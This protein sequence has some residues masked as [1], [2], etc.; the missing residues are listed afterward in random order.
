M[1][2]LALLIGVYSHIIF[3]L[4]IAGFFYRDYI[5]VFTL[6][7]IAASL[8][9]SKKKFGNMLRQYFNAWKHSKR[10]LVSI[11]LICLIALQILINFI[12]ALG[13]ELGFDSLWYHLTLPKI[14]LIN[15]S[16][17]YIPGGLF[18]YSAMP[19]LTEMLY[20]AAL[21]FGTET[22]AKLVHLSFGVLSLF[23]LYNLSRKFLSKNLS[24]LVLV[25]FYSSLV[26]GWMS[27]TAYID[28]SRTFFELMA[29]WG[30]LEWYKSKAKK[31]LIISS[32]MLGLAISVK[33]LAV[34]SL[35]IF[36]ILIIYALFKNKKN[37]KLAAILVFAYWL[38]A[39]VILLPWLVFSFK[40]TGN[41]ISPFFTNTYPI[42]LNFNLVNPLGL[43]DPISPIYILMLPIAFFIFKKL[44]PEMKI[45]TLYS[46][47][48]FAIW[49]LTPQT[50][51]GRFILPYL[52]AFSI[53]SMY[54]VSIIKR[55]Y[56]KQIFIGFIIFL[57]TFSVFY[58]GLANAKYLPVVLGKESK[59]QFLS[60]NLNFSFGD[61][62]DID[63][64]FSKSIKKDD[65]VL[66]YGLHNLYYVDFP[67]VDS[68][69]VKKGDR[70]NYIL[71]GDAKL[72]ERFKLW[73]LVYYN[74]KTNVKLYSI[75][76]LKWT[77]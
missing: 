43:S 21:S 60:K 25:L 35:L 74:E 45:I 39:I 57:G 19:K 37:I 33:L 50:G 1:F 27:T 42:S 73:N 23:A 4:G 40:N 6:F 64:Y 49:Y 67:F 10:K 58:R 71:I 53:V 9:F 55:A 63:G 68:S 54:V 8:Y 61:F 15:H 36:T 22:L 16:I 66:L 62:Y 41:P 5:V 77:Y 48:A 47:I 30:F 13:P 69:Y 20:V 76:G 38:W 34:S 7:Y 29:L 17:D 75:G 70:F 44:S 46:F 28:L 31:W 56:L 24:L 18:Y 26:V 52:P 59:S 72:P 3:A 14:Y 2:T 65:K 32:A 12:G 11:L 51:G